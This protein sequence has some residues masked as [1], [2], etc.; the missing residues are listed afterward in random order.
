MTNPE[1]V[2]AGLSAGVAGFSGMPK[3]VSRKNVG[4]IKGYRR[5]G[6]NQA[7]SRDGGRGVKAGAIKDA[8]MN[9]KRVVP[10]SEE[11]LKYVDK[12]ATVILNRAGEV[13]ST[14]GKPR[15]LTK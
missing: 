6:L 4:P 11:R 2:V 8:V 12:K 9:P 5:H 7:I 3:V 15:D 10:Q 1:L 13:I 14:Y